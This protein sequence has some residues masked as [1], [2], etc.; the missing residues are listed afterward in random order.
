MSN[1]NPPSPTGATQGPGPVCYGERPGGR[2][3]K[4]KPAPP[5]E[6]PDHVE[7]AGEEYAHDQGYQTGYEDGMVAGGNPQMT[8]AEACLR[9]LIAVLA[10]LD[11]VIWGPH[12]HPD[13]RIE[14]LQ[15]IGEPLACRAFATMVREFR[16]YRT[17]GGWRDRRIRELLEANTALVERARKAEQ[18][19]VLALRVEAAEKAV[20]EL[21]V[22]ICPTDERG[23]HVDEPLALPSDF[24]KTEH[25]EPHTG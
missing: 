1:P 17:D 7:T 12:G 6:Y 8:D 18:A 10:H 24:G 23:V 2:P 15:V 5:A 9:D 14:A 4:P 13:D 21:G 22:P 19:V 3:L 25:F 11:V 16:R 20:D